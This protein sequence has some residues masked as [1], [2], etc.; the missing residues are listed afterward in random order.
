MTTVCIDDL[1]KLGDFKLREIITEQENILYN[2]YKINDNGRS[3]VDYN[4]ERLLTHALKIYGILDQDY[5]RVGYMWAVTKAG[6][7]TL[8][9]TQLDAEEIEEDEIISIPDLTVKQMDT[10]CKET[11]KGLLK[12]IYT[13]IELIKNIG[14]N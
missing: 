11:Y 6:Y 4:V 7:T 13:P 9:T 14:G 8:L 2:D 10:F 5:K 1:I 12:P 3:M